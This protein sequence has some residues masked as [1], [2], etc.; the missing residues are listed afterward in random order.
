MKMQGKPFNTATAMILK[1]HISLGVGGRDQSFFNSFI[2]VGSHT[3][4]YKITSTELFL[5]LSSF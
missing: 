3:F 1:Y 4:L 5:T 2:S